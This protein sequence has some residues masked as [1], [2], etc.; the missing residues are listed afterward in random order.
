M[1]PV[2]AVVLAIVA[3]VIGG[4]T[5]AIIILRI[6]P[7]SHRPP[8][9]P[10]D[11]T[12]TTSET[13]ASPQFPPVDD[14]RAPE[15]IFFGEVDRPIAEVSRW[16]P[17]QRVDM[18]EVPLSAELEAGLRPILEHAAHLAMSGARWATDSY[19]LRFSPGATEGLA[20]G[21]LSLMRSPDGGIRAI[22]V[23]EY[24]QIVEHAKLIPTSG[25][26]P[27]VGISVI[28][29]VL[30]TIT[31]QKFISTIDSRLTRI[32]AGIAEIRTWLEAEQFAVLAG[33]VRYLREA[34]SWLTSADADANILGSQL[35]S[36]DRDANRSMDLMRR[37]MESALDSII[38]QKFDGRGLHENARAANNQ[39]TQYGRWSRAFLAATA[40]KGMCAQIRCTL[41]LDLAVALR[42]IESMRQ[43]LDGF[44]RHTLKFRRSVERRI[45]TLRSPWSSKVTD[46]TYQN[47]LTFAL[48]E[49]SASLRDQSA[50]LRK[51]VDTTEANLQAFMKHRGQVALVVD[52]DRDGRIRKV[53]QL[54][55]FQ[56]K[57]E[58]EQRASAPLSSLSAEHGTVPP[59]RRPH[60]STDQCRG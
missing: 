15:R 55:E 26:S 39:I 35:E 58:E 7:P 41:P 57:P 23:D 11:R 5:T 48:K 25:F 31:L 49:L 17:T 9:H 44:E 18:K 52:R 33:N 56:R 43:D 54:L 42:R 53:A 60:I 38:C 27:V 32:E 20:T 19:L 46:L 3:A 30:A 14:A 47:E 21:W 28:W 12:E 51:V 59:A 29:Q 8:I 34:R 1:S 2:L 24:G 6:R 10:H 37:Q 22:A 45:P 16:D 50:E 36:I 40:I 4:A 13:L